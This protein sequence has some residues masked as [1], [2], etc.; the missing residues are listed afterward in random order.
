MHFNRAIWSVFITFL[1]VSCLLDAYTCWRQNRLRLCRQ[2][3]RQNR[4]CRRHRS[5][6]TENK[7]ENGQLDS[8]NIL[9]RCLKV[10]LSSAITAA[11]RKRRRK[12]RSCWVPWC[13]TLPARLQCCPS[14][15]TYTA[16]CIRCVHL[17]LLSTNIHADET[18]TFSSP[19]NCWNSLTRN[20]SLIIIQNHTVWV[21]T[22][23]TYLDDAI[24]AVTH[25]ISDFVD[26]DKIDR[27]E[28][29][30]VAALG[31]SFTGQ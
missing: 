18:S 27:I 17:S 28:V 11:V 31:G 7:R 10:Y 1:S 2:S 13:F 6:V 29:D 22:P 26:F 15:A 21:V 25:I 12:R 3:R 20:Q 9:K 23:I 8:I 4:P 16:F 30:F 19:S 14:P 24:Y 5:C